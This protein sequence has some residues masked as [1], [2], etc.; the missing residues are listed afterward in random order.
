MRLNR[1]PAY[2]DRKGTINVVVETPRGS[3]N[4]YDFDPDLN[5]FTLSGVL[6][7][8]ASFPYDFGFVPSTLADDG[9]PVDVLLLMDEAAFPGCIVQARLIG[10]IEAEQTDV[11]ATEATRNDRLIAVAEA[12]HLYRDV[13]SIDDLSVPLVDSIVHFFTSYNEFKGKTFRVLGRYGP[14]RAQSALESTM[15]SRRKR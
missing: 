9:D 7:A 15:Q 6:F 12:S 3:R 14:K 11:E 13:R 2:A 10:V 5:A 8:G 1:L 4:K